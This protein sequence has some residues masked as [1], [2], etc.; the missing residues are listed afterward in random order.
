[1]A[2]SEAGGGLALR[3]G[4]ACAGLAALVAVAGSARAELV[5]DGSLGPAGLVP[6]DAPN[7]TWLVTDDLGQFSTDR[8]SLFQSF[9]LFDLDAGDTASFQSLETPA[10]VVARVTGGS[11]SLIAGTHQ[12]TIS[13]ADLFLLNPSGMVFTKDA[14]L[15]L[16]EF[17]VVHSLG[18]RS[19]RVLRGDVQ[20]ADGYGLHLRGN[21][22]A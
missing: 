22:P 20:V 8:Q 1:M 4:V 2:S 9:S 19:Q 6:F 15:D 3:R 10:R 21:S 17:A 7:S 12:S 5:L 16:E 18:R 11:P 14:A 13:G